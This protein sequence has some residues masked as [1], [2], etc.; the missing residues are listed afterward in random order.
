MHWYFF[1]VENQPVRNAMQWIQQPL[2]LS[3]FYPRHLHFWSVHHFQMKEERVLTT[4]HLHQVQSISLGTFSFSIFLTSSASDPLIFELSFTVLSAIN[5][6][7][8]VALSVSS[9]LLVA[10]LQQF[11]AENSSGSWHR[12][13][14]KT[15]VYSIV[16]TSLTVS[17]SFHY[18]RKHDSLL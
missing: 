12:W 16:K 3:T 9:I 7:Q 1:R 6:H 18:Y 11:A 14:S 17:R 8:N 2:K 4:L 5:D 13:Q 15:E 10:L